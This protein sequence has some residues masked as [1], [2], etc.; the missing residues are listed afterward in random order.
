MPQPCGLTI[1][2]NQSKHWTQL[3]KADGGALC[4][5]EFVT[6]DGCPCD[7]QIRESAACLRSM[8]KHSVDEHQEAMHR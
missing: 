4:G 5:A 1:N 3:M 6:M 2:G 8:Q 7:A